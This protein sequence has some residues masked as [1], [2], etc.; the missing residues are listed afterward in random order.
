MNNSIYHH[1]FDSIVNTYLIG[2]CGITPGTSPQIGLVISSFCEA[3]LTSSL[4]HSPHELLFVQYFEPVG[5]PQVLDLGLRVNKLGRSSVSYE[6]GVFEQDKDS[7]SA[8]G[9]YTHVFVDRHSRKSSP[10]A[11]ELREGLQN[12]Y[13]S[14]PGAG[15]KL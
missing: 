1:L 15:A 3:C 9:G 10:L 13:A 8:V 5:F 12:L 7:P 6:V 14:T 11:N 2:R 4:G